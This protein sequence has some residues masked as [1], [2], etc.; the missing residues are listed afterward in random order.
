M[1]QLTKRLQLLGTKSHRPRS[2]YPKQPKCAIPPT[3]SFPFPFP[4]SLPSL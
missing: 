3:S 4:P 1:Y 2:V